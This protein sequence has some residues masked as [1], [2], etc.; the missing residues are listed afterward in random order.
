[1]ANSN[2]IKI[3]RLVTGDKVMYNFKKK[4]Q[5]WPAPPVDKL[6]AI[7]FPEIMANVRPRA[8]LEYNSHWAVLKFVLQNFYNATK[9]WDTSIVIVAL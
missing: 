7:R 4:H 6:E 9:P 8:E 2:E 1:M 3:T 5:V